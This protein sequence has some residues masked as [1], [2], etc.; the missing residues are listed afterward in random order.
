MNVS[1]ATKANSTLL[2]RIELMRD[3]GNTLSQVLK[4][5]GMSKWQYG[6][7]KKTF[8]EYTNIRLKEDLSLFYLIKSMQNTNMKLSLALKIRGLSIWQYG[9]LRQRLRKQI[10]LG[11]TYVS[12]DDMNK[13]LKKNYSEAYKIMLRHAV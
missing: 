13:Y 5:M 10:A 6:A 12:P 11:D 8:H 3:N 4:Y 9:L 7:L 1:V 2:S